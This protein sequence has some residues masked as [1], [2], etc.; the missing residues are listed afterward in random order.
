MCTE[1]TSNWIRL[2]WFLLD[3]CSNKPYTLEQRKWSFSIQREQKA[4]D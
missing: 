4:M 1:S 3:G 2:H